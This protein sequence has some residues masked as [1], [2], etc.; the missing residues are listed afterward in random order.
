MPGRLA[1]FGFSGILRG[2]L[3]GFVPLAPVGLFDADWSAAAA[4]DGRP[5]PAGYRPS[6]LGSVAHFGG[7]T[8]AA[9]TCLALLALSVAL[10]EEI[11]D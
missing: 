10:R 2:F 8:H 1:C 5:P 4:G 9:F 7:F 3:P 6:H 11:N